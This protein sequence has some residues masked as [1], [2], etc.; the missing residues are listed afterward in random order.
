MEYCNLNDP[1]RRTS[2]PR[3][4]AE[5]AFSVSEQIDRFTGE[6]HRPPRTKENCIAATF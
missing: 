6:D 1:G 4:K 3:V 5:R 2:I